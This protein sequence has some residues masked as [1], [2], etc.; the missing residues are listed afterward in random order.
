M[1][2]AIQGPKTIFYHVVSPPF[3]F[4]HN[5]FYTVPLLH[6]SSARWRSWPITMT[7]YGKGGA[8][9]SPLPTAVD[10]EQIRNLQECEMYGI[11]VSGTKSLPI[12]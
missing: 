12:A 9:V 2:K 10:T 7:K 5:D 4:C 3:I 6:E 11:H 1:S 8:I